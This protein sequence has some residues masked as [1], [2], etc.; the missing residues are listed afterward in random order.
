MLSG[1]AI[2]LSPRSLFRV[3]RVPISNPSANRQSWGGSGRSELI[4]RDGRRIVAVGIAAKKHNNSNK[5]HLQ[6]QSRRI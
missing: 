3:K 5:E 1:L 6:G 4:N 2:T